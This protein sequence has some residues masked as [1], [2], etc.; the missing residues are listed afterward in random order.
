MKF[1]SDGRREKKN[2]CGARQKKS[3]TKSYAGYIIANIG[4]LSSVA[5]CVVPTED[6][7]HL[8]VLQ[9]DD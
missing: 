6:G 5:G 3:E 2:K 7:H 1:E 9:P 4:L 8:P